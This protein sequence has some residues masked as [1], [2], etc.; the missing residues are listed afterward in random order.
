MGI[1]SMHGLAA[2]LTSEHVIVRSTDCKPLPSSW[3]CRC[4]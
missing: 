2:A 3:D 1:A 4:A